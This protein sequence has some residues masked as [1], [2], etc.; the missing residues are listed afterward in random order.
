MRNTTSV[1]MLG[2]VAICFPATVDASVPKAPC[3]K[4]WPANLDTKVDRQLRTGLQ[5]LK[6][7][8]KPGLIYI[9]STKLKK[10]DTRGQQEVKMFRL[11]CQAVGADGLFCK[12]VKQNYVIFVVS[13]G[14]RGLHN[15][16]LTCDYSA[17]YVVDYQG[18][19]GPLLRLKKWETPPSIVEFKS[20]LRNVKDL[21]KQAIEKVNQEKKALADRLKKAREEEQRKKGAAGWL[22]GGKKPKEDKGKA[23][24]PPED[25]DEE[26]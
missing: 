23:P 5:A 7:K 6:K 12:W 18:G 10:G 20:T 4:G 17:I 9:H 8:K 11:F 21:K 26:E 24:R 25:E 1:F 13:Q 3:P 19:K 22:D 15:V 14:N 2:F 16:R